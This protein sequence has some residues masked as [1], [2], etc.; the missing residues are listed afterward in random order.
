MF[1]LSFFNSIAVLAYVLVR[2]WKIASVVWSI[3]H[4]VFSSWHSHGILRPFDGKRRLI[5]YL[6]TASEHHQHTPLIFDVTA[7]P[8]KVD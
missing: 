7:Y 1:T 5:G 6:Y 2:I 4:I 8:S 3:S